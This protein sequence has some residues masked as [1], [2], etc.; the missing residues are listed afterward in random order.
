[1]LGTDCLIVALRTI[2]LLV[3]DLPQLSELSIYLL[4]QVVNNLSLSVEPL[5]KLLVFLLQ[6]GIITVQF[7]NHLAHKLETVGK[8]LYFFHILFFLNIT[9]LMLLFQVDAALV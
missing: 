8:F 4:L 3:L 5:H 7:L 1:M 2:L 9:R 6:G